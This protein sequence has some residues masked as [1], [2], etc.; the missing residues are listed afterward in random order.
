MKTK[1]LKHGGKEYAVKMESDGVQRSHHVMLN[2]LRVGVVSTNKWTAQ[3][4]G[5]KDTVVS[6]ATSVKGM[7]DAGERKTL[8]AKATG[9]SKASLFTELEKWVT[10]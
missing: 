7:E 10:T 4:W 6:R 2:G 1:S 9:R 8:D 3:V 5:N